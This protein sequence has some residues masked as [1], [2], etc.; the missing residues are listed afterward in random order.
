MTSIKASCPNC[1][2]EY[3]LTEEQLS[4]ANGQV[5][6][7][8]C[9]TVFQATPQPAP[10]AN[11]NTGT[12][13]TTNDDA[14][15][16][17]GDDN[18][19]FNDDPLEDS[20]DSFAD[21]GFN[22]AISDQLSDSITQFDSNE[23]KYFGDE[24]YVGDL[25]EE[26]EPDEDWADQLLAE[27][28]QQEQIEAEQQRRQAAKEAAKRQQQQEAERAG[29]FDDIGFASDD[30]AELF[31]RITPE[32]LELKIADHTELWMTVI[33]SIA[34][35]CLVLIFSAQLFF[36]QFEQLARSDSW[37]GT[38]ET[39]CS[40][41][42]CTLPERFD[43][44]DISAQHLTV[45]SHDLYDKSLIVDS[46]LTNHA[47]IGQPFPIIQLYFTDVKQRVIAAREFQPSEYLRGELTSS[48]TM[49]SR[50]P[51]HIALEIDDPGKKASGYFMRLSY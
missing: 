50:Q 27:A 43:I 7:G 49:P 2:T 23:D 16:D 14:L 32:P 19:L 4:I 15:I 29:D 38:T 13:A 3:E 40:M 9:M 44:N 12:A 17:D 39:I 34:A 24:E 37:R 8:A 35:A 1:S 11:S 20:E 47:A 25:N 51:I 46:I 48:E 6:C 21:T 45:K 33:F 5:R 22:E 36:F 30:K 28:D 42:G 26:I 41:V 18:A 31:G 10:A